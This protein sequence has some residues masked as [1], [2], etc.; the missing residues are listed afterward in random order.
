MATTTSSVVSTTLETPG[1][2]TNFENNSTEIDNSTEIESDPEHGLMETAEEPDEGSG[3]HQIGSITGSIA[4]AEN[5]ST[6]IA[7]SQDILKITTTNS[8]LP[9]S[10]NP[11]IDPPSQDLELNSGS[12]EEPLVTKV[13]A[14]EDIPD[15]D[16]IGEKVVNSTS[17]PKHPRGSSNP[18][19]D[20]PKRPNGPPTVGNSNAKKLLLLS[21]QMDRLGASMNSSYAI[22][23][24]VSNESIDFD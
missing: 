10:Q 15:N 2:K 5:N 16:S 22:G 18:K 24:K 6:E 12:T 13:N 19:V 11:I 1:V 23:V 20:K 9:S 17:V 14:T 21:R 3:N 7:I 8:S 4:G